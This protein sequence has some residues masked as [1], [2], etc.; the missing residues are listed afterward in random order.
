VEHWD[1]ARRQGLHAGRNMA[2]AAEPY[3]A[4]P[5][6][7]SDLFD[8]SFDVWGNLSR[9]DQTVLRGQL[10]KRAFALFYFDRGRLTG[11]L[12]TGLSKEEQ[13]TIQSLIKER[14]AASNAAD[15]ADEGKDLSSLIRPAGTKAGD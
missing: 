15:L 12:V 6:F 13:K 2:G 11:A 14:T 9:W 5:N 8:L 3:T 1:V 4:L 10:E 7:F